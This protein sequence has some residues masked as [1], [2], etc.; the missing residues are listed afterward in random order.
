[1]LAALTTLAALALVSFSNVSSQHK[2]LPEQ[3]GDIAVLA[4]AALH[5]AVEGKAGVSVGKV[6]QLAIH[7]AAVALEALEVTERSKV[8]DELPLNQGN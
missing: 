7:V 5:G 8:K 6:V 1:M 2:Q 4:L 3:E